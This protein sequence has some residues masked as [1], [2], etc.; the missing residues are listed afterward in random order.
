M[1]T[2][3]CDSPNQHDLRPPRARFQKGF[4][5]VELLVVIA[6]IAL[7]AAVLLPALIQAKALGKSAGCKSNLRQ[8]GL[9]LQMY[10]DDYG[11]YPGNALVYR[12]DGSPSQHSNENP[13]LTAIQRY[14]YRPKADPR[15]PGLHLDNLFACPG[16]PWERS[17]FPL[18]TGPVIF[19]RGSGYSHNAG[20][21][22]GRKL[23]GQSLGLCPVRYSPRDDSGAHGQM[24]TFPVR[25]ETVRIPSD[26]IAIGD[27]IFLDGFSYRPFDRAL[28]EVGFL[29]GDHHNGGA[30]LVFCDG[31]VEYRKQSRWIESTDIARKRWN[32]DNDPHR[33]TWAGP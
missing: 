6:V 11:T 19:S 17:R 15:D 20:G 26:M 1:K 29:V 10:V 2:G 30:N 9:A 24:T 14:C 25:A 13:F 8:Q 33:E 21:T 32:N 4:T 28:F 31:H 27:A 7:L 22:A 16:R 5:L 3:G 18:V 12:S 23:I